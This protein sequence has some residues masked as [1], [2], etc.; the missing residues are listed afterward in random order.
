[1]ISKIKKRIKNSSFFIKVRNA[2]SHNRISK[3]HIHHSVKMSNTIA[4][5]NGKGNVICVGSGTVMNDLT[6]KIWGNNNKIVIGEKCRIKGLHVWIEDDNNIVTIG[7]GTTFH[8]DS[9][10]DCAEGK[11]ITIGKDCMFSSG[12]NLKTTDSHSIIDTDGNRVN[13]GKDITVGNHVWLGHNTY[14]LKG[15][16]IADNSV[17]GACS[18]VTKKFDK[19]NVV[20]VG[21]PAK[22]VKND[23]DWKRERI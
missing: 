23:I 9:C 21:N 16:S 2:F 6:I 1:M 20:I 11:N 17:I 15:S 13:V 18:V 22:I 7:D 3:K 10:F 4:L 8:G 5:D 14:L 12:V 19:T